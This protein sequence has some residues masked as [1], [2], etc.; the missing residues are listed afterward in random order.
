MNSCSLAGMD[1]ADGPLLEVG[2]DPEMTEL[3]NRQQPLAWLY[4]LADLNRAIAHHAIHRCLDLS[5]A[6]LQQGVIERG[7]GR[8][9]SS[10]AREH[11][12]EGGVGFR[13]I[14]CDIGAR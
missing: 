8:Q 11:G 2:G 7:L 13:A 14:G 10:L 3:G 5:V 6:E 9:H 1:P 4:P 12:L